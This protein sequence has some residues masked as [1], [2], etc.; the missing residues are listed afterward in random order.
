MVCRE[1]LHVALRDFTD[2]PTQAAVNLRARACEH[3]NGNAPII[4]INDEPA[5]SR[6]SGSSTVFGAPPIVPVRL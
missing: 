4:R 5:V 1:D 2:P 3:S 6:G